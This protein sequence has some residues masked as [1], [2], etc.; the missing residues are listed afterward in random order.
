[1][2]YGADRGKRGEGRETM[3]KLTFLLAI[4]LAVILST[5]VVLAADDKTVRTNGDNKLVPNALIQSTLRFTPGTIRVDSGD[6]VTWQH[7]DRTAEPHTVTIVAEGDLPTTADEVF[8]CEACGDALAAHFPAP[9]PA[10]PVFVVNV[11]AA[12]LDA[13]GDS[14]L[15]FDDQSVSAVVTA[16][17][18]STLLY[19]CAI[20]PWM[21]GE[22]NVR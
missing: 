18:G 21:Q 16:A 13:A 11:G 12:G 2:Y 15:L 17:S 8:S 7:D 19:L 20:H 4:G 14:L 1:M 9:P 22:I 5:G 3:R 6:V 10:P